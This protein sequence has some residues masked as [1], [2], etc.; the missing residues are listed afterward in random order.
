MRCLAGAT[1][2]SDKPTA[3]GVLATEYAARLI[4]AF[5]RTSSD[6]P[7]SAKWEGDYAEVEDRSR[8]VMKI[9]FYQD[10]LEINGPLR[11]TITITLQNQRKIFK[12][13]I[14]KSCL[15]K[16]NSYWRRC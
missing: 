3:E 15:T 6:M 8:N 5:A 4:R 7:D 13:K 2:Y 14:I 10:R 16:L 1:R 12:K 9:Y 11:A